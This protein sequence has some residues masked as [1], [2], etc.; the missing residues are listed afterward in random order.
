[1]TSWN[2]ADLWRRIGEAQPAKPALRQGDRTVTWGEFLDHASRFASWLSAQGVSEQAKVANYLYNCPEYLMSFAGTLLFRG[3]PVN[4]NYRYG[5]EEL[6][7]LFDNSDAEVLVF[8]GTFTDK[9]DAIRDHLPKLTHLIF[10]DDHTDP[11]PSWATPF[12]EV[13]N[14]PLTALPEPTPDDLIFLYTGGTTGMPKGVMWRQDDLFGRL[15]AGAI[16][17]LSSDATTADLAATVLAGDPGGSSIPACPLMHGTGLFTAM[18]TLSTGGCVILLTQRHYDPAELAATIDRHGVNVAVIVGDPFA[19]PLLR[20]L[21]T[22][23]GTYSLASLVAIVSSGAMWSEEIKRGL[24]RHHSGM[25]LMDNFASSEALGMGSSISSG[26]SAERT[27]RFTLGPDVRVANDD[28]VDV[29]PGSEEIGK[30]MLGGRNPVGYYKDEA[31]TAS[32]FRVFNGVRYSVPGDMARVNADGSIQL[33]GRGSQCI[34]TAGEKVFPEEVEETLKMHVAVADACV[35]GVADEEY[36]QRV[37]AAVELH[38]GLDVS[39]PQ[40]IEHVKSHLASY[41]APRAIRFVDTIGRADNGKMEYARH[42][43]EA[44]DWLA[45]RT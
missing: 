14:A 28:G 1:M 19:R 34:N 5:V 23:P 41:K 43:T 2:Y 11:C 22:Q 3:V 13:V 8:H 17:F 29:A 37:V 33:L 20:L 15:N 24:L 31:K 27:A 10:V 16:A 4:T 21:D 32:T 9:V 45:T 7:Y 36:G 26:D 30:L 42:Q 40:L 35:V 18:T 6:E 39:E 12:E 38:P 44:T 25:I